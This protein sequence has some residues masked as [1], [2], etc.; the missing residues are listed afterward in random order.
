MFGRP[1]S[2]IA[3]VH[4]LP[5]PGSASYRGSMDEILAAALRDA[6][7]Y[8]DGGVDALLVENMHDAPYLKGSVEPETTAAMSVVA[9]CLK[10]ECMMPCGVQILAGANIEA[11]AVAVAC[12]LDFIRVEGFVYA[13]V[14]DEGIHESNAACLMRRRSALKAGHVRVFADIK[15]KH[16]AHAI[17]G[18]VGLE[19]TARAAEFFLADGVVVSGV[20]TG[21]PADPDEVRAVRKAVSGSVLVGSGV[22]AENIT[23]YTAHSDALIIGS[24]FKHGGLWRNH[25]DPERVKRLVSR[26]DKS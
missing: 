9:D 14:G 25:V 6:L 7:A 21:S 11:L 20:S 18:D 5:L 23:L 13:H 16:S 12:S 10:R 4:V 3:V 15:K 1:C 2:I 24:A 19:E 8:K 22:T 17:T 26:L